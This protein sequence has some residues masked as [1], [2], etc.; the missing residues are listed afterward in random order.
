MNKGL[1]LKVLVIVLLF[2]LSCSQQQGKTFT[3]RNLIFSLEKVI[4]NCGI[5]L[6]EYQPVI[7]KY[8]FN[9]KLKNKSDSNFLIEV[10]NV[11]DR[12]RKDVKFTLSLEKDG[13]R[14]ELPLYKI[15]SPDIYLK[16]N[17]EKGI[18][19]VP[20]SK[21]IETICLEEELDGSCCFVGNL[22]GKELF[23]TYTNSGF[24]DTLKSK[25]GNKYHNISTLNF[26]ATNFIF[27]FSS[28]NVVK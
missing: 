4:S 28:S 17:T 27:E 9:I 2:C 25:Y 10:N 20:Y 16:G 26:E 7:P 11:L 15:T 8:L 22:K 21:D 1:S 19:L 5:D 14:I 13:K 24:K 6:N 18:A 12:S 23:F 3:E